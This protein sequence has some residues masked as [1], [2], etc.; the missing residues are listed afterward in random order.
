MDKISF[1]AKTKR[2]IC[3]GTPL[4]SIDRHC[5][6][7]ELAAVLLTSA[8][9]SAK[10]IILETENIWLAK[11]F[12]QLLSMDF[13]IRCGIN[14]LRR[15][16]RKLIGLT[17]YGGAAI[18]KVLN[19][20]GMAKPGETGINRSRIGPLLVNSFCCRRAFI[21]GAFL[22]CGSLTH[23]K[24]AYHTE[25][26]TVNKNVGDEIKWLLEE[27]GLNPKTTVRNDRYVVYFKDSGE[28]AD[29]LNITGAHLA[30][31]EF[32]NSKILKEVN[33]EI[34]R[35]AN[36]EASNAN[37]TAE[38]AVRQTE[39]I[40]LISEK[41]GLGKLPPHLREAAEIKLDNPEISMKDI[42]LMMEPPVGK[43]GINHRFR[44]ISGIAEGLR[45]NS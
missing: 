17:V 29:V 35:I 20:A 14:I 7:A 27:F 22:S 40:L 10:A 25:F 32:E 24:S 36:C 37:K 12:W 6:I 28:I 33:N 42:G 30:L 41:M 2:E 26:V 43:S 13:N 4:S 16:H 8:E 34:N 18:E 1:S 15:S 45:G 11:R 21:R 38:A 9:V 23:P 3:H 5:R 44:K 39:D 19:A 31:M